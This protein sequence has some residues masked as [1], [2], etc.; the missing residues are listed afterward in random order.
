MCTYNNNHH[1]HDD[2]HDHHHHNHNEAEL[3]SVHTMPENLQIEITI[4]SGEINTLK[5]SSQTGMF[6]CS[7]NNRL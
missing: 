3:D 4:L 5:Y 6:I 7:R 2:D 1:D